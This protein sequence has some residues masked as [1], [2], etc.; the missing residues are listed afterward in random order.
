MRESRE[1]REGREIRVCN[2]RVEGDRKKETVGEEAC[3]RRNCGLVL[4]TARKFNLSL[5]FVR[6]RW[7]G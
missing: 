4:R 1:G 6:G 7:M 2:G 3:S 5:Y